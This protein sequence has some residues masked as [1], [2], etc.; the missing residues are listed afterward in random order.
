MPEH[1]EYNINIQMRNSSFLKSVNNREEYKTYQQIFVIKPA[2]SL[3][4]K[5]I[6]YRSSCVGILF[7]YESIIAIAKS[8]GNDN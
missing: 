2:K 7:R 4:V 3:L 8:V 5:S 6:A 1:T